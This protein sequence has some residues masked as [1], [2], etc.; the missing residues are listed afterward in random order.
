MSVSGAESS[1]RLSLVAASRNDAHG[2]DML[3]RMRLFIRALAVQA[4]RHG[5]ACEL[6]LVE[7]N[8][9]PENPRLADILTIPD[10]PLLAVR[11]ITVPEPVHRRWRHWQAVPLFQMIAKNVGIRRSRGEFVLCTNVDLLFSD[12]LSDFLS[13]G[14]LD[15]NIM[16]RA[17]RCDVPREILS[18]GTVE[19]QL[20]WCRSHVIRRLGHVPWGSG[21][22]FPALRRAR[23]WAYDLVRGRP[24]RLTEVDT[25]ACGDFT[26]M[27][28]AAWERIRG[29]PELGMY[30]IHVD[31]LGCQA[32]VACGYRQ[33]V[34]PPEMCAYHIDHD[35]GWM[36]MTPAEKMKFS[37]QRPTLDWLVVCE[38]T[39]WMHEHRA[40]LPI[41]DENWGCAGDVFEEVVVGD[42]GMLV[43]R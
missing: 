24:S 41:N 31:S 43:S 23:K 33:V 2:G 13:K 30:S 11:V 29:Y 37:E 35:S 15:A 38:A 17:N 22:P 34:L 28:R 25:D 21:L 40:P 36:S 9:V 14:V 10:T 8:P 42:R 19:E 12:E 18:V 6:V 1:I 27:S 5:M 26:L 20:A 16:Y 7:W 39:K 4:R 32:A 3:N